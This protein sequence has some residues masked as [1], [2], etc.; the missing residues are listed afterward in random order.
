MLEL[1]MG[2][3]NLPETVEVDPP[4]GRDAAEFEGFAL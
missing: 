4:E 2:G 1:E 3:W